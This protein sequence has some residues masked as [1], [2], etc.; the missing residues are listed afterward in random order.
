MARRAAGDAR[1]RSHGDRE[2]VWRPA[3][4][5]VAPVRV[6]RLLQPRLYMPRRF[7]STGGRF[8]ARFASCAKS[9]CKRIRGPDGADESG[10]VLCGFL[11]RLQRAAVNY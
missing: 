11:R 6:D 7:A 10:V 4:P 5:C 2:S 3:R 8:A 1:A 9:N